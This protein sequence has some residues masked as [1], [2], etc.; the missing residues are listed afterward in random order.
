MAEVGE[1]GRLGALGLGSHMPL[2]VVLA[3]CN[4]IS[5]VHVVRRNKGAGPNKC[6]NHHWTNTT[7]LCCH[8]RPAKGRRAHAHGPA[9]RHAQGAAGQRHPKCRCGRAGPV[10][11]RARPAAWPTPPC[12]LLLHPIQR[13]RLWFPPHQRPQRWRQRQ[14]RRRRRRRSP[15]IAQRP[16][17]PGRRWQERTTFPTHRQGSAPGVLSHCKSPCHPLLARPCGQACD[18]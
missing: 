12:P 8:C 16:S 15:H 6:T 13:C 4:N 3:P 17:C 10:L 18:C 11:H 1:T 2:V 14:W 7:A 9:W 5:G